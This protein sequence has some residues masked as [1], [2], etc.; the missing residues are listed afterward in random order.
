MY[1]V[2]R[3]FEIFVL[4]IAS[5]KATL[6]IGAI[7]PDNIE[8]NGRLKIEI[9]DETENGQFDA[10]REANDEPDGVRYFRE[11]FSSQNLQNKIATALASNGQKY[12]TKM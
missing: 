1:I 8:R 7:V 12:L 4:G 10:N 3:L 9:S 6:N 2:S 11:P 5:N